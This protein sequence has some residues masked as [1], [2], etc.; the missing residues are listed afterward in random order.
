MK[1]YSPSTSGIDLGTLGTPANNQSYAFGGN[2]R[3]WVF[4]KAQQTATG[5]YLAFAIPPSQNSMFAVEELNSS[6]SAS[7]AHG[8]NGLG[9]VVGSFVS[10]SNERAAIWFRNHDDTVSKVD[11]GL[12]TN[13]TLTRAIWIN[14]RGQVVGWAQGASGMYAFI[15][16][17]GWTSVQELRNF[18]SATDKST[19]TALY[20]ATA[21]TDDGTVVGYGQRSGV[22]YTDGFAIK[23]KL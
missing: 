7:E 10:G 20:I 23:P 11:L 8:M 1:W 17:P 14:N 19:W 16:V 15:W 22:S 5:P 18:L 4:G 3:G 21:I 9:Q 12:L 13:T 6:S 2:S